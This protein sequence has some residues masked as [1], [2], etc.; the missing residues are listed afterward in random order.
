MQDLDN[1]RG[2]NNIISQGIVP[3]DSYFY[4]HVIRGARIPGE[5]CDTLQHHTGSTHIVVVKYVCV[6]VCVYVCV[7]IWW[8]VCT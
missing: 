1:G 7:C 6:C 4:D 8:S 2:V 5:E 3:F